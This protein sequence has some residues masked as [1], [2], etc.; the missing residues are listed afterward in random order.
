MS[1]STKLRRRASFALAL[2]AGWLAAT[3]AGATGAVV[4][5]LSPRNQATALGPTTIEARVTVSPGRTLERLEIVVDAVTIATL[6]APPWRTVWDA[7]DGTTGHQIEVRAVLDGGEVVRATVHA[8]PLVIQARVGVGLVNLFPVVRDPSGSYVRGLTARDF[9]VLED[10]VERPIERFTTEQRPLR[11][12]IVLDASQSMEGAPIENARAAAAGLLDVLRPG[13]DA[14]VVAFSDRVKFLE[15]PTSDRD[16]LAGAIASVSASGGTALYDAVWRTA[17]RLEPF[18]GRRV[19]VLLSDGRDEASSG[20]GPGSL[21]T[22]DEAR[23][24]AVRSEAMV[25]AIALGKGLDRQYAREWTKPLAS[26]P[27][28]TRVTLRALLLSLAESTG[29]RL[30]ESPGPGALRRAFEQVAED[31]RNQYS[32]AYAPPRAAGDGQYHSIELRIPGRKVQVATRRG[33]FAALPGS[34]PAAPAP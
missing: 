6:S 20:F 16:R 28:A 4:E 14:L 32:L 31:L 21:H 7:G 27:G 29:G 10:G 13:D 34:A 33:Y 9:V 26:D 30:F 3:H 2:G 25:F 11:I 23:T 8:S 18:D 17:R 12:G 22:L 15:D 19:L 5:I 24:Q 1:L